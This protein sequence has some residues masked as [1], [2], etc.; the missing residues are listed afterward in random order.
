M[1]KRFLL[2]FSILVFGFLLHSIYV[3]FDGFKM[4]EEVKMNILAEAY[5]QFNK[6]KAEDDITLITKIIENNNSIPMI[7]TSEK[8]SILLDQNIKYSEKNRNKVLQVKLAE[9][10]NYHQPIKINISKNKYQKIYYAPSDI[11]KKLKFYPVLLVVIFFVFVCIVFTT[12]NVS[13]INQKNRLWN[14]MAKETAHQIGTPLSSLLG[15]VAILRTEPIDQTYVDE[16]EKDVEHLNF[17][18]N[19]FSKIGSTPKLEVQNLSVIIEE[20]ITYFKVRTSKNMVFNYVNMATSQED[21]KLNKDL[22]GWVLENLFK[23]AIDA[24]QGKGKIEVFLSND[25]KY[26]KLKIIDT[27]KGIPKKLYNKVFEPGYTTKERGWGLGLSL[28]KRII[29]KYH[30]G[31][32][33]IKESQKD[34]GTTF[35]INFYR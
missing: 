30:R 21:L 26:F 17:I 19:R 4:Q 20:A 2:I 10:K 9:M 3:L 12:F 8:D 25:E 16:I 1:L 5:V 22:I 27:G 32:I 7:V 23:N 6:V 33:F 31:K 14:G 34:I 29:E 13:S 11:L 24:M 18:A 15:W 28:T 35:Q